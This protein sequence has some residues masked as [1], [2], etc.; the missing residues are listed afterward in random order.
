M[1]GLTPKTKL[2][3]MNKTQNGLAIYDKLSEI[4]GIQT[5]IQR[6]LRSK[7]LKYHDKMITE[8]NKRIKNFGLYQKIVRA[9]K[10]EVDILLWR[11]YF[12][13]HQPRFT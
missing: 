9:E 10:D 6:Y 13:L 11:K 4:D 2:P 3:T 7:P 1:W 8:I 12:L 5:I